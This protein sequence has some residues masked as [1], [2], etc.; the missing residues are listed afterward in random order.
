MFC[1]SACFQYFKVNDFVTLS[2]LLALDDGGRGGL[3]LVVGGVSTD[4]F[5]CVQ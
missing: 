5:V 2:L 1:K 4:V 3:S